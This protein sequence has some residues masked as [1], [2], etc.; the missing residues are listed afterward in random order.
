MLWKI[1]GHYFY[2][3]MELV[4]NQRVILEIIQT[5]RSI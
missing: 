4:R 1:S 3:R 5:F 2:L